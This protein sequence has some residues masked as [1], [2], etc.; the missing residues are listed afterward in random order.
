MEK[1]MTNFG[2]KLSYCDHIANL[3]RTNLFDFEILKDVSSVKLDLAD[4]GYLL[5]TKKTITVKDTNGLEYKITV[6]Q[7]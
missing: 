5:S 7:L 2:I 3:I 4:E 6:E 1:A